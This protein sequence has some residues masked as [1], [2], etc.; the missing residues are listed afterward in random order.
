M[1][2]VSLTWPVIQALMAARAAAGAQG[3]AARVTSNGA[4]GPPA[5]A[6][7]GVASRVRDGSGVCCGRMR[8]LPRISSAAQRACAARGDLHRHT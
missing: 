3:P 1:S 4:T 8:D 7:G 2:I 6:A 5:V